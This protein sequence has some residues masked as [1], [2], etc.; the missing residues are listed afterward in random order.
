[1]MPTF[2]YLLA[3]TR[4]HEGDTPFMY[5][6]YPL[7]NK[8]TDV[9]VGVGLAV[10]DREAAARD[11]IRTLFKLK[12]NNKT[13]SEE[14]MRKEY[15]RVSRIDRTADNLF[16]DYAKESPMY[17]DIDGMLQ[18]LR[19]KMLDFWR[20]RGRTFPN[21]A[22]FPAQ[23]QVALMSYNYGRRLSGA[24]KMCDAVEAG[25]YVTARKE[26]YVPDWDRLKNEAHER[27]FENAYLRARA[28]RSPSY[29]P[30]INGPFKPPP[31][32]PF[33]AD[34]PLALVPETPAGKWQVKIGD[35]DGWFVFGDP[36]KTCFWMNL[37]GGPKHQG[38]WWFGDDELQWT[39]NDEEKGWERIFHAK[40]PLTEKMS[41]YATINGVVH[42]Y[43]TM[44]KD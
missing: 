9:T 2:E 28:L 36:P 18:A 17:M 33:G 20:S 5:N 27:L 1:M 30:P 13:P 35:W 15:D 7:K 4:A 19:T 42:G 12:S 37:A 38:K 3:F 14:D 23:V 8:V 26:A 16:T 40:R 44:T 24:P 34:S 11:D 31:R 10:S 43:Y 25:D 32:E 6:N 39:Y 41:G 21:F 22:T 29:L